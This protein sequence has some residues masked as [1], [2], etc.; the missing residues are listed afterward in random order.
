MLGMFLFISC[1]FHSTLNLVWWD[2]K[3]GNK[4]LLSNL[5]PK[6]LTICMKINEHDDQCF[7]A[8][9]C[10]FNNQVKMPEVERYFNLLFDT[11]TLIFSL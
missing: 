7:S 9:R 6:E 8:K 2:K 5:I 10:A 4:Y 3:K 11:F 1:K